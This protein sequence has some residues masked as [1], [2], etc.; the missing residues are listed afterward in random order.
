MENCKKMI[1]MIE[2][3]NKICPV[4]YVVVPSQ[5]TGTITIYSHEKMFFKKF[6]ENVMSMLSE[7]DSFLVATEDEKLKMIIY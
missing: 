3:L 7:D 1:V 6:V 5:K 4:K 2:K